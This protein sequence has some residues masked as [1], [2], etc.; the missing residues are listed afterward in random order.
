MTVLKNHNMSHEQFL[1][2]KWQHAWVFLNFD[3]I[4]RPFLIILIPSTKGYLSVS[5]NNQEI[6]G[7]GGGEL[8]AGGGGGGGGPAVVNL[9]VVSF[10]WRIFPS[11]KCN[12][13]AKHNGLVVHP[14]PQSATVFKRVN[15]RHSITRLLNV[16]NAQGC[17][18]T[19]KFTN[20]C[21]FVYGI[22]KFDL[23]ELMHFYIRN[24]FFYHMT[25]NVLTQLQICKFLFIIYYLEVCIPLTGIAMTFL[26]YLLKVRLLEMCLVLFS[27]DG[28]LAGL[29]TYMTISLV[30]GY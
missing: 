24:V 3:R 13:W 27:T 12:H 20:I 4:T 26:I 9:W 8:V 18:S 1:N 5:G 16:L 28:M 29:L 14:H 6:V 30:V 19:R 25:T 2:L 21:E 15:C 23:E 17:A 11:G 7:G 10:R 22:C